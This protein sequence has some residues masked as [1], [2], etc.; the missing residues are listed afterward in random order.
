VNWTAKVNVQLQRLFDKLC[1]LESR[2]VQLERFNKLN[3]TPRTM[4]LSS[5][6]GE[7]LNLPSHLQRTFLELEKLK[8]ATAFEIS[9]C[10]MRHR[11]VESAYLNQLVRLGFVSKSKRKQTVVFS[12]KLIC[13][14]EESMSATV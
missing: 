3:Q 8:S 12:T 1:E 11:A 6:V 14:L 10:T 13:S 4:M 5:G 2:V 9:K 7:V